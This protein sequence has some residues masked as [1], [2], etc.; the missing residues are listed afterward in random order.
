[1]SPRTVRTFSAGPAGEHAAHVSV[2]EKTIRGVEIRQIVAP[3]TVPRAT[4]KQVRA[5]FERA[6]I[7]ANGWPLASRVP[8]TMRTESREKPKPR[9]VKLTE[10]AFHWAAE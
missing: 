1:M 8:V 10:T 7:S 9:R 2:A 3:S 5:A 6:P 4:A